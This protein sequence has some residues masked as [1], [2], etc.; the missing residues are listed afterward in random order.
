MDGLGQTP[1]RIL[2]CASFSL[3]SM[4][5]VLVASRP[6]VSPVKIKG[7]NPLYSLAH[8]V[9]FAAQNGD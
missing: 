5:E 9:H 7:A 6:C 2:I 8:V 1:I 4:V 3:L